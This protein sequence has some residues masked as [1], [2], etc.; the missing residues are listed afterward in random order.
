MDV[1]HLKEKIDLEDVPKGAY[2]IAKHVRPNWKWENIQFRVM[3]LKMFEGLHS[4]TKFS[5]A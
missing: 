2:R 5:D 4:E 3:T 1:E